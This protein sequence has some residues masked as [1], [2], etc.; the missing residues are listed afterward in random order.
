MPPPTASTPE[1][2]RPDRVL[3]TLI[4]NGTIVTYHQ[5]GPDTAIG[6]LQ[7]GV[8]YQA[9]VDPSDPSTIQL[10]TTGAN[11]GQ[12]VQLTANATLVTGGGL[13]YTITTVNGLIQTLTV[14]EPQG[15]SGP[16]PLTEGEAVTYNGAAPRSPAWWTARPT[17]SPFPTRPTRRSSS[18][19]THPPHC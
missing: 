19:T 17:T 6:G 18:S 5:G 13:G 3:G 16:T 1:Q 2:R 7:D 11:A 9:V 15:A 10:V 14:T 12:T 8:S 4:P